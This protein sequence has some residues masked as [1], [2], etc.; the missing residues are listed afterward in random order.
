M[1][2][3]ERCSGARRVVLSAEHVVGR[4]ASCSLRLDASYVSTAHAL[5]RWTGQ[6]W[7]LRDLGSLNGT[8]VNGRRLSAGHSVLIERG[9]DLTFGDRAETWRVLDDSGPSV[10][11][12]PMDG[13]EPCCYSAG[14]LAV[15]SAHDPVVTI[16]PD[17]EG[18]CL[19][20]EDEHGV[21]EPGE[22]FEAAGRTWRFEC[23]LGAAQTEVAEEHGSL[24]EVKLVF[25]VSPDEEHVSLNLQTRNG[26][27]LPLGERTCFYLAMVLA[28]QRLHDREAGAMEHGWLHVDKVLSM[29]PDYSSCSALNVEIHRLRRVV[30][31][32][33]IRD[34]ARI[35]E[36]RRG[37]V[38]LG[39]DRVEFLLAV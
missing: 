11:A 20:R 3:L 35:V 29:V 13:G 38:R 37:Q 32:S 39:T 8:F 22:Q 10:V 26:A 2:I 21:I 12:V 23:P 15:P 31:D 36:R 17:G 4:L 28:R 19:E 34:A 30:G 33:N 9:V 5:L 16:F 24:D 14:L 7:E 18:W 1:A 6:R 27:S 25:V